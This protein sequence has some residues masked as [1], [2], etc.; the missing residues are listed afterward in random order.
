[1]SNMDNAGFDPSM[2]ADLGSQ[3]EPSQEEVRQ[4]LAQLRAAP[5]TAIVA[6]TLQ[7][8]LDA[9]QVKMGRKDGR[10]LIDMITA[11]RDDF[12]AY[13]DPEFTTQ[14]DEVLPQLQMGQV[15][16]EG[17]IREALAAGQWSESD[18][19]N[20]LV[21]YPASADEDGDDA[22]SSAKP[23]PKPAAA[24]PPSAASRLWV[25]GR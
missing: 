8:A 10:M 17:Q 12:G 18:D 4:Y 14:L 25:P 7:T 6:Q 19:P 2:A 21:E 1:M 16:A 15:E 9:V 22:D 24:P 3:R 11:I 5:I 20:D 23:A 13:L